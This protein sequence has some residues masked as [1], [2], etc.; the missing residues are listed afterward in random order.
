M[1]FRKTSKV[2][3]L[4]LTSWLESRRNAEI[5]RHAQAYSMFVGYPRTG[6]SLI[7]SLLD[8]HPR[9]IIAHELDVLK[10]VRFGF[11]RNQIFHLLLKNSRRMAALGRRHSGYSYEVP[12]QWQGRYASLQVLGDKRGASSSMRLHKQP[13]VVEMLRKRM[14]IDV[15]FIHVMRN[16]Y[17]V[18]STM[19]KC[20]PE[21][22]LEH[23][24]EQFFNLCEA[25]ADLK[26]RVGTNE[27]FDLRLESFIEAPKAQLRRLCDFLGLES[28]DSYLEDCAR[29]VFKSARKTRL[30]ITWDPALIHSVQER[31]SKFDFLTG[32]SFD[33]GCN[34]A[35]EM[36]PHR[37]ENAAAFE[38][39]L[40]LQ[41]AVPW[42]FATSLAVT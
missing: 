11:S 13:Q 14:A 35:V 15:K 34:L 16:P 6:H 8:A 32:Y 21:K 10:L 27:L 22:P 41:H 29:I 30:E 36:H 7:G 42:L 39:S 24:I 33:D 25:V 37:P 5:F 1:S 26:K 12:T 2:L 18:L 31:I 9:V 3:A 28:S 40:F 4:Y 20:T 23:H 38:A 19:S 17:D